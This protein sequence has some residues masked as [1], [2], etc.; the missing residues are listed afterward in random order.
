MRDQS[1]SNLSRRYC[2]L[3]DY[4][5]THGKKTICQETLVQLCAWCMIILLYLFSQMCRTIKTRVFQYLLHLGN[6]FFNQT[7]ASPR[8][9]KNKKISKRV[10]N[11]VSIII[12]YVLNNGFIKKCAKSPLCLFLLPSCFYQ[13]FLFYF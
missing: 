5:V 1:R 4:L 10:L 9:P 7:T 3:D 11:K 12:N 2:V 8:L 6:T 13:F